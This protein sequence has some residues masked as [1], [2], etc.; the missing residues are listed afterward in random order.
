MKNIDKF[1]DKRTLKTNS[2]SFLDQE[3]LFNLTRY[4]RKVSN[5]KKV[6]SFSNTNIAD[7]TY[8][9]TPLPADTIGKRVTRVEIYFGANAVDSETLPMS[10]EFRINGTELEKTNDFSNLSPEFYTVVVF[11]EEEL[12]NLGGGPDFN[13]ITSNTDL[14]VWTTYEKTIGMTAFQIYITVG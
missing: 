14:G 3:N 4:I 10:V 13:V 9:N 2:R 7:A 1:L 11:N 12:N 8:K 6:Y 5:E